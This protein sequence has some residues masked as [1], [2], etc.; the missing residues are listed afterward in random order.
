MNGSFNEYPLS[1]IGCEEGIIKPTY[2]Y[3]FTDATEW[4]LGDRRSIFT[5]ECCPPRKYSKHVNGLLGYIHNLLLNEGV[6]PNEL[7]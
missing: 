6:F 2:M 3:V 7:K 1:D 4:I 5:E